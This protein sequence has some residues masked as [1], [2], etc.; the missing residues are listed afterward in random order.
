MRGR[1]ARQERGAVFAEFVI[2]LPFFLLLIFGMIS[3]GTMFSFRQTL[4]QAATE[5]ARAAAASQ[6]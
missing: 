3:Y 4:S 6:S 2:V 1:R 5:G